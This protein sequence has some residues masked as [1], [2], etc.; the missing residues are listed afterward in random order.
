MDPNSLFFNMFFVHAETVCVCVTYIWN[1]HRRLWVV[2]GWLLCDLRW[3]GT[4]FIKRA[5]QE[6]YF[7]PHNYYTLTFVHSRASSTENK[8]S[9]HALPISGLPHPHPISLSSTHTHAH[10]HTLKI[11]S[12]FTSSSLARKGVLHSDGEMMTMAHYPLPEEWIW[13]IQR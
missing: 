2:R 12:P 11:P 5:G 10:A 8:W 1:L 13:Y 6:S 9:A 3:N 7:Y 4:Q